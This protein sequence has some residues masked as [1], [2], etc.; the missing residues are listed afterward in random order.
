[1]PQISDVTAVAIVALAA[2]A[3][4]LLFARLRQPAIIGYIAAGVVLGPAGLKLISNRE[5][6]STLAEFGVLMLL[7]LIGMQLDL[8][9][10]VSGW[11]TAIG[12]AVIQI[13]GSV[14]VALLLAPLLGWK[15]GLAVL[16]GFAVSVSSTAVGIK[17][18]EGSEG[19][20][21]HVGRTAIGVL[22]AQDMA[23]VPMMLVLGALAKSGLAVQDFTKIGL[24]VLFLV[25]LFWLLLRRPVRLPFA[26]TI[27]GHHDLSPLTGLAWCF[28]AATAAELA[29]LSAAYGAFLAGVVIGNSSERQ[30]MLAGS[31]PIESVLMVAF[32]LSVGLLLDPA[33]IWANLGTVF[34]LLAM[35]TLFKTALNILALRL[36]GEAWPHAFLTGVILA[37][38]GEFSFLLAN[39]GKTQKLIGANDARLV[40]AVTVL[41]LMLSPLWLMAARRIRLLAADGAVSPMQILAAFGLFRLADPF[42]RQPVEPDRTQAETAFAPAD[43]AAPHPPSPLAKMEQ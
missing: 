42:R 32:F 3:C 30:S 9:R 13:A 36:L 12:T 6:V 18:I 7:F 28:G 41:S 27:A 15:I 39:L 5:V 16:L 35:V 24:S 34:L 14:G 25:A 19:V 26:G 29:G 23:V 11:R 4:G 10:F 17:L 1:M 37:Q 31:Q 21:S 2:L 8:R 40:V 33:F 43:P 22:I 38:I 20:S